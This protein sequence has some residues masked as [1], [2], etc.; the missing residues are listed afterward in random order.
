MGSIN[1]LKSIHT[2]A[3]VLDEKEMNKRQCQL[4]PGGSELLRQHRVFSLGRGQLHDQRRFVSS[5]LGPTA[6][7]F[8]QGDLVPLALSSD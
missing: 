6:P 1:I 8:L 4:R 2:S 3:L 7:G 5:E